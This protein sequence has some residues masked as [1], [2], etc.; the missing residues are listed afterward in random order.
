[1]SLIKELNIKL[2]NLKESNNNIASMVWKFDWAPV[3]GITNANTFLEL[4]ICY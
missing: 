2:R 4:Q 3:F 1:M